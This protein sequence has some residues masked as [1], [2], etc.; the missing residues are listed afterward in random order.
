MNNTEQLYQYDDEFR[1][2][3]GTVDDKGKRIWVFAKKPFG[4]L[5]VHF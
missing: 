5:H 3:I 4:S 2:S 1:N